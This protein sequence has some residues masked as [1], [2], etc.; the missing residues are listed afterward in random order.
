MGNQPILLYVFSIHY[1]FIFS[2][3]HDDI[4]SRVGQAR[5]AARRELTQKS[6]LKAG[7]MACSGALTQKSRQDRQ[8]GVYWPRK[9]GKFIRNLTRIFHNPFVLVQAT[10]SIARGFIISN[11]PRPGPAGPSRRTN[12]HAMIPSDMLLMPN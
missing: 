12:M 5:Q 10:C 4:S 6:R 2:G 7:S 9:A 1:V 3:G 11:P 8:Q